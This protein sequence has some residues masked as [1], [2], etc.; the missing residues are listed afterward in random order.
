MNNEFDIAIV[1]MSCR[2]PGAATST[3]S[4]VTWP[5]ESSRLPGFQIRRSWNPACRRLT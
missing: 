1:G 3:N 2:L 4:G 5:T